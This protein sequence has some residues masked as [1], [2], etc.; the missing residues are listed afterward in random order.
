MPRA[1]QQLHD[2]E[3]E[4]AR[5]DSEHQAAQQRVEQCATW[6]AAQREVAQLVAEVEQ[7]IARAEA[8]RQSRAERER[9]TRLR[10]NL[11]DWETIAGQ[12]AAIRTARRRLDVAGSGA[13]VL[14]IAGG[15]LLVLGAPTALIAVCGIAFFAVLL[16]AG[17]FAAVAG[18]LPGLSQSTAGDLD[19]R[20]QAA[21]AAV[22]EQGETAPLTA[23]GVRQRIGSV[24]D[25]L[26]ALAEDEHATV[27]EAGFRDLLG[28]PGAVTAT[29]G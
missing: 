20:L 23:P 9:L 2:V 13:G 8:Q 29:S 22:Y 16:V 12:H 4:Y 25:A 11:Q 15:A 28:R 27:D 7:A 3:Q 14:A 1:R 5:L 24:D 17:M 18:V 10:N 6:R 26:A 21:A 19:A